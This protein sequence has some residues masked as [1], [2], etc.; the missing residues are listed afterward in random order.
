MDIVEIIPN[1]LYAGRKLNENGWKF[2][3]QKVHAI[4]NLREEQDKPPFDFTNRLL[5]W[6]PISAKEPPQLHWVIAATGMMNAVLDTGYVLYV[7][8]TDGINRLGF[9]LTAFY[10]QRFG[11]SRHE[12]LQTVRQRKHDLNPNERYMVLLSQFEAYLKSIS[13][14]G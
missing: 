10:M 8:D 5:I 7:H 3:E 9:I 6:T 2:I 11:L 12:A 14:R 13:I 1:H 4:L